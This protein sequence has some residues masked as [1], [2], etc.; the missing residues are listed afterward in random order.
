MHSRGVPVLPPQG[1]IKDRVRLRPITMGDVGLLQELSREPDVVRWTTYPANLDEAGA[2]ARIA[3]GQG[4]ADRGVFCVV[5]WDGCAAG[6]CGAGLGD[7][8]GEIGVFYAVLPWARR[9]GVAATA[10]SLLV[11]AA[12]AAG[13]TTV[14]LET[15]LDNAASEAVARRAGFAEV[16]RHCRVVKG[17]DAE[18]TVWEWNP[19]AP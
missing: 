17:V 8:D 15:H 10:V 6:T 1:L 13:A 18:V 5:E 4:V 7:A 16:G 12:R 9:K 19:P 2:R 14:G 3:W 11:S